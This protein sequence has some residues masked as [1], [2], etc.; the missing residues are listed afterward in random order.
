MKIKRLDEIEKYIDDNR[1]ASTVELSE[2]FSISP[3]TLRRDLDTLADLGRIE[4]VYG[5]ARSL[6]PISTLSHMPI[7]SYQER[8]LENLDAKRHIGFLAKD[9][10][11]DNECIFIDSGTTTEHLIVHINKPCSILTSSLSIANEALKHDHL[12]VVM[13]PGSLN[14]RTLSF[15]GT[16][17]VRVL[18]S[19]H[20]DI[21]YMSA[22]GVSLDNGLTISSNEEYE[23]KRTALRQAKKKILLVD[24]SKINKTAVRTYASVNDVDVLISDSNL[25]I[26]YQKYA[27][28]NNILLQY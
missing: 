18:E 2:H 21:A 17:T 23:V 28:D 8:Q 5:G 24:S 16:D 15:V 13:L 22:N 9:Y 10:L 25:P 19:F 6:K 27:K 3:N 7:L 11:N 4:K 12:Q 20:V 1:S 26:E 14:R